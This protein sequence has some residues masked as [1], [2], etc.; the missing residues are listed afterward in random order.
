M[1]R[2]NFELPEDLLLILEDYLGFKIYDS[3]D[4]ER[5]IRVILTEIY[6][7]RTRF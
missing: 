4:L 7:H 5:A 2:I 6:V 1:K 3:S